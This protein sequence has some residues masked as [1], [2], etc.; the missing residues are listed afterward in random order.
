MPEVIVLAI[1]PG[2]SGAFAWCDGTR[3]LSVEDMPTIEVRGKKKVSAASVAEIMRSMKV[4]LV[5]IEAVHSMPGQGVSSSFGFGRSLGV[6]EGVAAGLGLPVEMAVP[7]VWKRL[8]GAPADKGACRQMATQYWPGKAELF[9]RA[10]DDGRADAA[11]L[12]R[13]S[14]LRQR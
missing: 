14:A 1:D 2:I 8:A 7:A 6:L 4:D 11:L 10:K 13:W 9:K 5:V 3:L 12:A